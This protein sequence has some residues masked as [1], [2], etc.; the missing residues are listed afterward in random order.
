MGAPG[1]R[2]N[3]GAAVGRGTR[4]SGK[5]PGR[6]GAAS[7]RVCSHHLRPHIAGQGPRGVL[8]HLVSRSVLG[9]YESCGSLLRTMGKMLYL[10]AFR[11]AL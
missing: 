6:A 11:A 2:R 10:G 5:A 9:S 3:Q 7:L 1:P 8:G 4:G